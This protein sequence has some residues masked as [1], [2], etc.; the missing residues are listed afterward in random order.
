MSL[1][2]DHAPNAGREFPALKLRKSLIDC[3][4]YHLHNTARRNHLLYYCLSIGDSVSENE[5]RH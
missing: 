4:A 3:I 2:M 5:F 1:K